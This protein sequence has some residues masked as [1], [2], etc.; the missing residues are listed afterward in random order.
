MMPSKKLL[1]MGN[2]AGGAVASASFALGANAP[3][4]D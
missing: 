3:G 1:R 4:A 2:A